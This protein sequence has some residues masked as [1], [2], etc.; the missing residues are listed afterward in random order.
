VLVVVLLVVVLLVV[1]VLVVQAPQTLPWPA[2]VP[3]PRVHVA[4]SRARR[5]LVSVQSAAA[6]QASARSLLQTPVAIPSPGVGSLQVPVVL[7]QQ[8]TASSLPQVER[9]AQRAIER[10]SSTPRQSALRRALRKWTTQLTYW[11]WFF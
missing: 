5:A 11:P 10:R 4:S 8:R 6:S 2:A 1:V 9:A 7:V 3:P